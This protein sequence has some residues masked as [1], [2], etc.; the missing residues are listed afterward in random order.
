M[1]HLQQGIDYL[2]NCD[3]VLKRIIDE[4]GPYKPNRPTDHFTSMVRSIMGQQLSVKAAATIYGRL[5]ER[6]RGSLSPESL[7]AIPDED[8]RTCGVSRQKLGYLRDLSR[9]FTEAPETFSRLPELSDDEV[10]TALTA[11]KGI[12]VW[13]AQMFLMFTLHRPDVFAPDDVGL[14]NAMKRWYEWKATPDKK[15]LV[16]K[17][18][19]WAPWRTVAC[20]YLWQSLDNEP[21]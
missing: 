7:N 11:V 2:R 8:F 6:A 3:S 15:A 14:Q 10:I 4:T 20:W 17:A 18:E 9:H 5:V 19:D 16:A 13:T 1:E 21:K 12:G